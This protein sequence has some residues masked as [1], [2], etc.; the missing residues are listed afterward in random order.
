MLERQ[1]EIE[2]VQY[3]STARYPTLKA[4]GV[5]VRNTLKT[6]ES[7]GFKTGIVGPD[8]IMDVV[9]TRQMRRVAQR[10]YRFLYE[11]FDSSRMS[12]N[13]R[14]I[15]FSFLVTNQIAAETTMIW[16]RDPFSIILSF[17]KLKSKKVVIEIH[18]APNLFELISFKFLTLRKTCI[19]APISLM[20]KEQ[21]LNS[22]MYFPEENVIYCPMGVPDNFYIAPKMK[23]FQTPLRIGYIGGLKSNGVDQGITKLVSQ[24][25]ALNK[26]YGHKIITLTIIG[27]EENE[28]S[29]FHELFS[30][31]IDANELFV[32]FRESQSSILGKIMDIDVWILP[33]PEGEFFANR[34]P[35]KAMEYAAMGKPILVS[36][37]KSHRNIFENSEVYFYEA[38]DM[39]SLEK[40]ILDI[41]SDPEAAFLR[42]Q[43]SSLKSREF[44]Y[45]KR[46]N[47][48]LNALYQ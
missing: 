40:A 47:R 23:H 12:F 8:Q 38:S 17:H 30:K 42:S 33:Y 32:H 39:K 44:T 21:I 34:F 26:K 14:R 9:E 36:N 4:Y 41:M 35:L 1:Q 25:G 3:F 29:K 7:I 28:Y 45:I 18:Q 5:T 43:R 37:T 27:I 2:Y 11:H 10:A 15:I 6:L 16:I 20:L 48:V 13:F 24:V 22:R 31:L 19:L 46:V